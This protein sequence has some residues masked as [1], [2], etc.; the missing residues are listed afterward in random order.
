M[1]RGPLRPLRPHAG[2]RGRKGGGVEGKGRRRGR[3][4]G[5]GGGRGAAVEGEEGGAGKSFR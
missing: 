4:W 2:L 5:W 3:G 1:S